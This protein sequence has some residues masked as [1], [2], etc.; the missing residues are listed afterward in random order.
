M[1]GH[2]ANGYID[3]KTGNIFIDREMAEKYPHLMDGAIMEELLHFKQFVRD[4]VLGMDMNEI[5][6]R[7]PDYVNRIETE[8]AAELPKL[9]LGVIR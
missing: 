5:V 6:R 8:V 3:P 4:G 7:F 9:G 2:K 1:A